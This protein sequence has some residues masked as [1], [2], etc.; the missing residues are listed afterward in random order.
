MTAAPYRRG[1]FVSLPPMLVILIGKALAPSLPIR[2]RYGGGRPTRPPLRGRT[3]T[4]RPFVG[5]V[6]RY[7]MV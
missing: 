3:I 6:H 1:G 2:D 7:I 5:A 4:N